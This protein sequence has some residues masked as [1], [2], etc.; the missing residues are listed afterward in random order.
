[1]NIAVMQPY[2]FPYL[3]YFQLIHAANLFVIFDDVAYI[4]RGWINRNRILTQKGEYVFTV[5]ISKASQN[6]NINQHVL[7]DLPGFRTKFKKLLNENYKRAAY[8]EQGYELVS[9]CLVSDHDNLASFCEETIKTICTAL[10]IKTN[11]VRSSI[12]DNDKNLK[13]EQKIIDL[14]RGVQ[15]S[16]YVNLPGGRELYKHKNFDNAGLQLRFINSGPIQTY[17][18]I[19]SGFTPNLSIIDLLMCVDV[20]DIKIWIGQYELSR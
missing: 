20:S 9:Q 14:V 2:A 1:M 8:F 6:K 3:G 19:C 4:K 17:P 15:G 13:A 11:M 16:T 12:L 7:A 18:Q 10:S 5:P